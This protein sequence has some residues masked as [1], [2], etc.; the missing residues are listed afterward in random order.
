MSFEEFLKLWRNYALRASAAVWLSS[1]H[2]QV[3]PL[4]SMRHSPFLAQ[5]EGVN[6]DLSE[7]GS[8]SYITVDMHEWEAEAPMSIDCGGTVGSPTAHLGPVPCG[9][10]TTYY[11]EYTLCPQGRE[12]NNLPIIGFALPGLW[13][14]VANGAPQAICLSLGATTYLYSHSNHPSLVKG[15]GNLQAG[16]V[17]GLGLAKFPFESFETNILPFEVT[18]EDADY[19]REAK[20]PLYLAFVTV[21]GLLV[22][23]KLAHTYSY[24][25]QP[26]VVFRDMVRNDVINYAGLPNHPFRFNVDLQ[27]QI[28]SSIIATTIAK[29]R[30]TG[31]KKFACLSEIEVNHTVD[32]AREAASEDALNFVMSGKNVK[33]EES[34]PKHVIQ[35]SKEERNILSQFWKTDEIS[36]YVPLDEH[37]MECTV[38]NML[39]FPD[40]TLYFN[41]YVNS[42]EVQFM[43]PGYVPIG[44][45]ERANRES[46]LL[47]TDCLTYERAPR[48]K[49]KRYAERHNMGDLVKH[50]NYDALEVSAHMKRAITL[51]SWRLDALAL[52]EYFTNSDL[53]NMRHDWVPFQLYS[54]VKLLFLHSNSSEYHGVA[55]SFPQLSEWDISALQTQY[56]NYRRLLA[57]RI[58]PEWKYTVEPEFWVTLLAPVNCLMKLHQWSFSIDTPDIHKFASEAYKFAIDS[59]AQNKRVVEIFNAMTFVCLPFS[60][61]PVTQDLGLFSL[62]VVCLHGLYEA[63]K[64]I[65]SRYATE[66]KEKLALFSSQLVSLVDLRRAVNE[67]APGSISPDVLDELQEHEIAFFSHWNIPYTQKAKSLRP[68][69]GSVFDI[70]ASL[71]W[72]FGNVPEIQD[73]LNI[74]VVEPSLVSRMGKWFSSLIW[75]D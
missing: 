8:P 19:Y 18:S 46:M 57:M 14:L 48:D 31:A 39:L 4:D 2:P 69:C 42:A 56:D 75:E 28:Y 13:R 9:S 43:L 5:R 59:S 45:D 38:T 52:Y 26:F 29:P 35:K 37:V 23:S 49:I 62:L 47:F 73:T 61:T 22:F 51:T 72:I 66:Y 27:D 33:K 16:D 25:L 50:D 30:Y 65:R 67:A 53:F 7:E 64:L 36:T 68:S 70:M 40:P 17:V 15:A 20:K 55:H 74:S 58:E 32:E 24:E 1:S 63:R 54:R 21:N 71:L 34:L 12:S 60:L 44:L 41:C 10:G 11:F 6:G 3:K